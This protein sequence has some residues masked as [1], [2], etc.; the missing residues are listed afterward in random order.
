M[1]AY[2]YMS[3]CSDKNLV[4][5]LA[6]LNVSVLVKVVHLIGIF[7]Y[8]A[9]TTEFEPSLTTYIWIK[10]VHVGKVVIL[11]LREVVEGTILEPLLNGELARS[12]K[13]FENTSKS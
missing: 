11:L 2:C 10:S 12:T 9:L 13:Q 7:I 8:N 4:A 3:R 1:L 6:L 5:S